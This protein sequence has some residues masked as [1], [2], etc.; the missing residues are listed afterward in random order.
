MHL[1][2]K[3]GAFK[4]QLEKGTKII[5]R[6]KSKFNYLTFKLRFK[7]TNNCNSIKVNDQ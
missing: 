2:P 5:G 6:I 1:C 7:T 3:G 4:K